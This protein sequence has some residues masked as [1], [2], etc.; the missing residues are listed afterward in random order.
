[1]SKPGAALFPE[2]YGNMVLKATY[3]DNELGP[4]EYEDTHDA[5]Y[6]I[7][8]HPCD[9]FIW[10]Q[11]DTKEANNLAWEICADIRRNQGFTEV[12]LMKGAK[13]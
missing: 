4:I 12:G 9:I 13:Q 8:C 2:P 11:V 7:K 5:L 3:N 1:M 6:S 10:S